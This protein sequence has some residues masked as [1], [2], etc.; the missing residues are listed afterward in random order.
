MNDFCFFP[1]SPSTTALLICNFKHTQPLWTPVWFCPVSTVYSLDQRLKRGVWRSD[2]HMNEVS[3]RCWGLHWQL[4]FPCPCLSYELWHNWFTH[5][6]ALISDFLA[7]ELFAWS[8]CDDL[9]CGSIYHLLHNESCSHEVSTFCSSLL[10]SRVT[11]DK[12]WAGELLSVLK[13]AAF[14]TSILQEN[15]QVWS[16]LVIEKMF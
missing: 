4:F 14:P 7:S 6:C 11:M 12:Y 16:N 9:L 13:T 8:N 1:H 10:N 15:M 5:Q 2:R 3:Q